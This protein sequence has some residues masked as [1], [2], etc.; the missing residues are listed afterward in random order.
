MNNH[1]LERYLS[2]QTGESDINWAE[3]QQS[4][5][6]LARCAKMYYDALIEHGFPPESALRIILVHGCWPK[7]SVPPQPP[8][9]EDEPEG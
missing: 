5:R 1:E 2:R 4:I 6:N 7:M 8:P 9:D 3:Q